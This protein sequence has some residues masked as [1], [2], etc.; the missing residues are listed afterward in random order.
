MSADVSVPVEW[1]RDDR[2][3]TDPAGTVCDRSGYSDVGEFGGGDATDI[4]ECGDKWKIS[5]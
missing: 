4:G 1:V 3:G 2:S 5:L